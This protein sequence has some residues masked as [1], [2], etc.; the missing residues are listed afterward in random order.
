MT[1]TVAV[2]ATMDTKGVEADFV[3][4]ELHGF[5][6]M[7]F[8]LDIGVVGEPKTVVDCTRQQV[9]LVGGVDFNN[10]MEHPTRQGASPVMISGAAKILLEKIGAGEIQAVV[11]MGGSQ[12]TANCAQIFQQLPY[13]FP[14]LILS[15]VA[16]GDTSAF[17]DIKDITMMP[18][19]A[20]ILGLNPFSRKIL[21]NVAGAAFGMAQSERTIAKDTNS[22]GL[23]GMTN[24][25]VLTDGANL[26]IE[27]FE[28]A[29]YEV[30]TFH[31]VGTG[32]R[33]MEQ[34]M[35]EGLITAVFDYALGEIADEVHGGFRAANKSRLTV[36][37]ELGI[38]Q[39]IC[40]GGA[41][42]I[43][44]W[45]DEPNFVPEKYRDH[46]YVF[47]NPYIFVPR[48]T[49]EEIRLVG[50]TICE[51]LASTTGNCVVLIPEQGVSRYSI[52][53]APLHDPESDRAFFDAIRTGLPPSIEFRS[54]NLAAE[55]PEF[56]TAAVNALFGLIEQAQ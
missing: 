20:D 6:A 35:R 44:L 16:S 4:S 30:I 25:G 56:V 32:G 33:A 24:L 38:P 19:V 2:V 48:L 42:H 27:L 7:A 22:K 9:A 13:G 52:A 45:V 15:T 49:V 21:S 3:R 51:R 39:V 1:K 23:I 11:G 34:M 28:A 41:E 17:M 36:A 43:G 37:G 5:G 55:D 14:K 53:G 40:P 8:L 18:A 12:G 26:A 10:I 31:A 50:K 46:K 47:H 29:G 54:L